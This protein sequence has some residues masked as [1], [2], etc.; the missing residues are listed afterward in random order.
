VN[1]LN[2]LFLGKERESENALKGK[3]GEKGGPSQASFLP[4]AFLEKKGKKEDCWGGS[5]SLNLSPP[6][7]WASGRKKEK[8][9][10]SGGKS[11]AFIVLTPP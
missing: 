8:R 3:R 11:G 9:Q 10:G 6:V 7:F 5:H 4:L 1:V 2:L